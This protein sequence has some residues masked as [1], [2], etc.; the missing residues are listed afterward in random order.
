[1]G[2]CLSCGKNKWLLKKTKC[3]VCGKEGCVN[4]NLH[5]MTLSLGDSFSKGFEKIKLFVCPSNCKENFINLVEQQIEQTPINL[6]ESR[7]SVFKYIELTID[8]NELHLDE[9]IMNDLNDYPF[10]PNHQGFYHIYDYLEKSLFDRIYKKALLKKA[11]IFFKVRRF[12]EAAQLYEN[13]GMYEEAGKARAEDKYLSIKRT[14]VSVDLN[15]L[16]RQ[17]KDGGLIVV[18]R[19]PHCSAPLKVNK[20][21]K[22]ESLRVC[23]HCNSEI[24]SMD[25]TEFL[26]TALS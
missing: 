25:I 14:E 4:C 5:I 15:S 24:E 20:E 13:L 8:A 7:V 10:E 19:C 21:T 9:K 16:L 26:K 22:M 11:K 18:Y 17:I 6:N 3:F 23:K 2:K 12:E 1:M